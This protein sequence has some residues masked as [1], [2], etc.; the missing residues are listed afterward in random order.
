[1]V[2]MLVNLWDCRRGEVTKVTKTMGNESIVN[3]W[4]NI[5]G[6]TTPEWISGTF[7]QYMIG[8]GFTSRCVFVYGEKKRHYMAYP[9]YHAGAAE[10]REMAP[11]L[12]EDLLSIS[13][14]EGEFSL[15]RQAIAWGEAWYAEHNDNTDKGDHNIQGYFARKQTHL[16]KLAMILSAAEGDSK[17]IT[18]ETLETAKSML[19][20][21]ET[22]MPKVF[23]HIG[24]SDDTRAIE[25]FINLVGREKK[26][27]Y[28]DAYKPFVRFMTATRFE[29]VV[30]SACRTGLVTQKTYA[31]GTF[32]LATK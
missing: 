28:A 19:D 13:Q 11:R 22:D 23:G 25:N 12:V 2:D 26:I 9:G 4:I 1:M 18:L 3:P 8:G 21:A 14:L 24:L 7:P 16:H 6:C 5:L 31:D 29:E 27:S 32:F 20:A 10:I 30:K 17:I 15:T